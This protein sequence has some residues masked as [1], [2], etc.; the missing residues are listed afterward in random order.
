MPES[1]R[2]VVFFGPRAAWIIIA[3]NPVILV[4]RVDVASRGQGA[5]TGCLGVS[6][7]GR[8]SCNAR[9]DFVSVVLQLSRDSE[10]IEFATLVEVDEELLFDLII[11]CTLGVGRLP[12]NLDLLVDLGSILGIGARVDTDRELVVILRPIP[13]EATRVGRFPLRRIIVK[14]INRVCEGTIRVPLSLSQTKGVIRLA[15]VEGLHADSGERE[16]VVLAL[17]V[18]R[19]VKCLL[20]IVRRV[21]RVWIMRCYL[22]VVESL[23]DCRAVQIGAVFGVDCEHDSTVRAGLVS[24]GGPGI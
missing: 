4:I 9:T 12:D 22:D 8:E 21:S 3:I 5:D 10:L 20:D 24:D 1:A 6:K 16:I 2:I 17:I 15:K 11:A 18:E 13:I 7:G 23:I 14:R 19:D